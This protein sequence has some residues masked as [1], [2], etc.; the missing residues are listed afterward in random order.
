MAN[1]R[2]HHSTLPHPMDVCLGYCPTRG[3]LPVEM[4]SVV[5]PQSPCPSD[6]YSGYGSS[7]TTTEC[8]WGV[9][10]NED[11]GVNVEDVTLALRRWAYHKCASH[12]TAICARL[13][14]PSYLT[15]PQSSP[16]TIM[17][18]LGYWI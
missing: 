9:I 12:P 18:K 6:T 10:Y 1:H 3:V 14:H 2:S 15:S 5:G 13:R 7:T 16:A 11:T 8:S 17:V 4:P